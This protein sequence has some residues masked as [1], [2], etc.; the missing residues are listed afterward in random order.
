MG[1][2]VK[3]VLIAIGAII[4]LRVLSGLAANFFAAGSIGPGGVAGYGSPAY[5]PPYYAGVLPRTY[6]T[7]RQFN[8][9]NP[10]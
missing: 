8:V 4:G 6:S 1:E 9:R 5:L 10:R 2:T 3:W 7:Y